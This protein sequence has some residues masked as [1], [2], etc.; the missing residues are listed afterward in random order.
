MKLEPVIPE[1]K[2]FLSQT[3]FEFLLKNKKG[4]LNLYFDR[5]GTKYILFGL[6]DENVTF[7]HLNYLFMVRTN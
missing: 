2:L 4:I 7:F 5:P 1:G 3:K 6:I